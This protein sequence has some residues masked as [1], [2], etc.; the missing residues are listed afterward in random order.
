MS[1]DRMKHLAEVRHRIAMC[2]ESLSDLADE[3]SCDLIDGSALPH[4]IRLHLH[5]ARNMEAYMRE[6][7]DIQHAV[8]ANQESEI[9]IQI[10]ALVV[11]HA[12][13]TNC[14]Q[15]REALWN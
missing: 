13:S 1:R 15:P 3:H 5:L 8:Q 7:E 14:V 12:Q 2:I 10:S 4:V 6:S 11:E 9:A